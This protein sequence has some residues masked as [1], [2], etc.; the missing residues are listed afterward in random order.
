MNLKYADDRYANDP[1]F[2]HLV[3][4]LEALIENLEMTPSEIREAAVY[5]CLRVEVR[6]PPTPIAISP[7]LEAYL[8]LRSP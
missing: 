1:K 2:H 4:S 7:D 8:K 6:R 5:A 3:R